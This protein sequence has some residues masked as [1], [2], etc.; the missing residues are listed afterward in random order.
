[1]NVPVNNSSVHTKH[2]ML[3]NF[4]W[5]PFSKYSLMGRLFFA[6]APDAAVPVSAGV[7]F[8]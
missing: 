8:S 3:E 2:K 4:N 7:C 5:F 6:N 1:M